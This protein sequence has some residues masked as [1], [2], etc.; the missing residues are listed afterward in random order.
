[1]LT[2]RR[3]A[4]FALLAGCTG[5]ID[6]AHF[7]DALIDARCNYYVRCGVA[8]AV[9]ECHA[10]YARTALD[11]ASTQS[12]LDAGKLVYHEDT[13]QACLDAHRHARRRRQLRVLERMRHQQLRQADV[14]LSMLQRHVRRAANAPRGRPTVH[15]A[16][17]R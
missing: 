1:M 10:F 7:D 2:M 15:S 16:L 8:A 14:H 4:V 13:A 3:L 11:T 17:R 9:T 12:A 5:G 6:Y